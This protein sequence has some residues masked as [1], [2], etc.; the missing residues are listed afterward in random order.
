MDTSWR[1]TGGCYWVDASECAAMI[2]NRGS[3]YPNASHPHGTQQWKKT[4]RLS[5]THTV[6]STSRTFPAHANV[7]VRT[8]IYGEEGG[9]GDIGI[10]VSCTVLFWVRWAR[11][12]HETSQPAKNPTGSYDQLIYS[13]TLFLIH[14]SRERNFRLLKAIVSSRFH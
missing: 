7:N 6:Q 8:A 3:T 12:P 13:K 1:G 4:G 9:Y 5:S 14:R 11:S 2:M 10:A